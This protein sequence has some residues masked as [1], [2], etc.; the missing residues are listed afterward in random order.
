[1]EVP[2]STAG[3][4]VVASDGRDLAVVREVRNGTAFVEP[5]DSISNPDRAELGWGGDDR[6]QYRLD[7]ARIDAV[8][9]DTVR[10]QD[11]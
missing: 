11:P 8:T 4:T 7:G 6:E 3:A 5:L 1:M 2:D 10:L 9:N